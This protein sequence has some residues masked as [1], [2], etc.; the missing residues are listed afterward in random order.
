GDLKRG[1]RYQAA[2]AA[3]LAAQGQG[4]PTPSEP[5]QAELRGQALAWLKA[6]L[7][8]YRAKLQTGGSPPQAGKT[9]GGLLQKLE[10]G[11]S[12]GPVEIVWVAENLALWQTD[13][14][15]AVLREEK[16]LAKLPADEQPGWRRLWSEVQTLRQQ[17]E[18]CFTT[19]RQEGSLT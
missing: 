9:H 2:C 16:N 7:D 3:A 4:P 18:E 17:A 10:E 1:L 5:E 13:S 14:A 12:S 19:T 6:D 15:L 8:Q 11:A